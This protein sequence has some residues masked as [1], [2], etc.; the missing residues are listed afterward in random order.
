MG[1]GKVRKL[2]NLEDVDYLYVP[3]KSVVQDIF[4]NGGSY[5]FG[6]S[7]A[8]KKFVEMVKA[9]KVRHQGSQKARQAASLSIETGTN[10]AIQTTSTA[11]Q[12]PTYS[13]SSLHPTSQTAPYISSPRGSHFDH[14]KDLYTDPYAISQMGSRPA[15]QMYLLAN[16]HTAMDALS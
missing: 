1:T 11:R 6:A 12:S 5:H 8:K 4:D 9:D 15:S 3:W 10:L 2:K 14:H 16:P 13:L 7:S